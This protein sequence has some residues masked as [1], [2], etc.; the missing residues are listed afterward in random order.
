[1]RGYA[2]VGRSRL[3]SVDRQRPAPKADEVVVRIRTSGVCGSDVHR[4]AAPGS[5]S[6]LSDARIAGHDNAG[7]IVELGSSS[8]GERTLGERVIVYLKLGCM[9]CKLCQLGYPNLCVYAR[10]LGRH[11]D[12]S[13]GEYVCVPAW[14]ALP[15]PPAVSFEEGA[16]ISCNFGT[17]YS[18]MRKLEKAQGP[19]QTVAVMGA[20][21]VG[22]FCMMIAKRLGYST[23]VVELAEARLELAK[24]LGAS[25]CINVSNCDVV[26]RIREATAGIGVDGAIECSGSVEGRRQ[27]IVASA[28]LGK[29]VLVGNGSGGADSAFDGVK[30]KGMTVEGSVLYRL[31]EFEGMLQYIS[32]EHF[33]LR[34]VI[35]RILPI[36]GIGEALSCAASSESGKV[37]LNY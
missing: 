16:V 33:P 32:G 12:G 26:Q 3:I 17:A 23:V 28:P 9:C 19:I 15:L 11:I 31:N 21:P 37:L 34:R 20:G 8:S 27:A 30:T 36:S 4:F 24:K 18:A 25:E 22:I 35:S 13:Y 1:M 7:E 29:V 2:F 6:V 10:N 5:C 14:A